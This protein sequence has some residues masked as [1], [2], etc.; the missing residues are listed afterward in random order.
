MASIWARLR[1]TLSMC[2]TSAG[3]TPAQA[4]M[5]AAPTA[6]PRRSMSALA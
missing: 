2:S 5:K 4:A 6:C 1:S 3:N